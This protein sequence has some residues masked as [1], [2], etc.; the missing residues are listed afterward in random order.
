[1]IAISTAVNIYA[2]AYHY[3]LQ[4]AVT[5][6]SID[7]VFVFALAL[8][9][10]G[11]FSREE[12]VLWAPYW[13]RLNRAIVICSPCAAISSLETDSRPGTPRHARRSSVDVGAVTGTPWAAWLS[14]VRGCV[15]T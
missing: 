14:F 3:Q 2:D 6:S 8:A 9:T 5:R 13:R 4:G 11:R 12:L 10:V 15:V 7:A 1:M